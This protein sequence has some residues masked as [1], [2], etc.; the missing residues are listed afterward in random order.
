MSKKRDRREKTVPYTA[1]E[2]FGAWKDHLSQSFVPG[3][4]KKLFRLLFPHEG[5]RR[6]YNIKETRLASLLEEVLG[7]RGLT[8]WDAVTRDGI[9]RSGCLGEEVRLA[10]IRRR[11]G[12]PGELMC[13]RLQRNG[14]SAITI[15]E[16]DA[17]LDQL[18]ARSSWSQLSQIPSDCPSQ[19]AILQRLYRDSRLSPDALS[20]LTQIILRDLRPLLYPLPPRYAGNPELLIHET[21]ASAPEL[22][23]AER[24]MFCWDPTM[25]KL[26]LEGKGNLDWCATAAEEI[27]MSEQR[28]VISPGPILGVNVK[29]RILRDADADARDPE[30][31]R[32][33]LFD[34]QCSQRFLQ[35]HRAP[36]ANSMGRDEVRRVSVRPVVT[37]PTY[38]I[39]CRFTLHSL[40]GRRSRSSASRR[41]IPRMRDGTPTR[42]TTVNTLLTPESFLQLLAYLFLRTCLVEFTCTTVSRHGSR[43]FI[44]G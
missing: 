5:S 36:D 21:I 22:L 15:S 12:C 43:A 29:V 9:R 25:A 6:R 26:Y 37:S 1:A 19:M 17:L 44:Q 34:R 41:G 30:S 8:Q 33:R 35:R 13:S 18:A 31:P 3:T 40:P 24:A 16:V 11:V 32:G 23:S 2:I 39:A 10:M 7:I 28:L 14:I 4:T 27:G 38:S 20:V 42:K